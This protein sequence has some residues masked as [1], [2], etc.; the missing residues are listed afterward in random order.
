[1]INKQA[2]LSVI[3][4]VFNNSADIERT[5]KSVINQTYPHIEY[6]IIDGGSTD[7]TLNIIQKHLARVSKLVSE[8][9]E[10]IYDAMNKGLKLASGDYVLF[11]NSGDEIYAADTVEKVFSTEEYSDIYYG[12][13]EMFNNRW[14]SL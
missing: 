3:T 6:I 2:T 1:M 14:E 13:T 10:G 8:K 11:M 9:D 12:E 5:I 4:V 7:G